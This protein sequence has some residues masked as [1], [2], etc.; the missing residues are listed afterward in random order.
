MTGVKLDYKKHCKAPFGCY[1]QVYQGTDN[2]MTERTVAAICLGPTFNQSGSYKF[3]KLE[4]GQ[5]IKKMKFVELPLPDD[6]IL[7]V[8]SMGEKQ[9]GPRGLI[10]K[11]KQGAITEQYTTEIAGVYS[12]IAG[13]NCENNDNNN[14]T[15]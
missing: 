13:V 15:I 5:M 7:R 2:S 10:F 9:H 12:N 6:V 1:T 11:N 3:M 14:N 4:S 8:I